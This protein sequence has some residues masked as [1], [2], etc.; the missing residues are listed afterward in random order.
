[1]VVN[2]YILVI[3]RTFLDILELDFSELPGVNIFNCF[4]CVG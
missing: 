3:Y 1:M 4:K 2:Q